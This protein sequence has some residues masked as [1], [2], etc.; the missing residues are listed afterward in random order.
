ME[1]RRLQAQ[2]RQKDIELKQHRKTSA[3]PYQTI[4]A[5]AQQPCLTPTSN[6]LEYIIETN[7]IKATL[8]D[9]QDHSKSY[10]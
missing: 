1:L 10:L 4:P 3:Q 7:C 9:L 6:H 2:I 8:T 5:T